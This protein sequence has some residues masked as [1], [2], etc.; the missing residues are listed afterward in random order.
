MQEWKVRHCDT[1]C[2]NL[3]I[4]MCMLCIVY[5]HMCVRGILMKPTTVVQPLHPNCILTSKYTCSILLNDCSQPM[6]CNKRGHQRS[7][8]PVIA[9]TI[10]FVLLTVWWRSAHAWYKMTRPQTAGCPFPWVP[11][12]LLMHRLLNTFKLALTDSWDIW[13]IALYL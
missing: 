1:L 4:I 3:C 9:Q 8:D 7:K 5:A 13:S 11:A 6:G 10:Y 12:N 2:K